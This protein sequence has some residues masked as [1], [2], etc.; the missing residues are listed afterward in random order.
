MTDPLSRQSTNPLRLVGRLARTKFGIAFVLLQKARGQFVRAC[1]LCR[2]VPRTVS[3]YQ[4][5]L[6]L[7]IRRILGVFMREGISG[8]TRRASILVGGINTE[9]HLKLLSTD[10]YGEI[11]SLAP[12]F[13]PK[14]SIIVPNFNHAKYLPERLESIYGQ[15]YGNFEVILLDDCSSD[16]S[17]VILHDYAER[18]SDK[19]ICR[20]NEVNSG[21]VF[22]QWRKGLELATGELVWI[23]ESDDCCS[24]NLLE[25]LVRCFQNPGVMLA[26]AH[27]EFVRGTPAMKAWTSKE[28]LAD[29]GFE[30]WDHPFIKSAHAM[31]KSGWAIKN[32]IPNVSGAVFRHPGKMDILEDSQWL[33]LRM[34]GDW[35]FYLSIIRG[36]LVA[37]N[38]NATNYYR[39]HPQNT[40][41][42]TQR[43]D[44]YYQ[45]H[46]VVALYL[47]KL[48][49]LDRADLERQERVLYQHWCTNRGESKSG[50][51]RKLYDLDKIWHEEEGRRPNIVM[52][53]YALAA[54]GGETFPIMLANLLQYRGY[55]VTLLNCRSETTE[56]GVRRMLL[57]CIP[58]LELDR[59]E[60]AGAVFTDMGIELVHSH[61]AW[62]D[63]TLATLLLPNRDIRQIVTMHGM[64][65]MM[66]PSQLKALL[67]LLRSR[68]DRFV[69]TAGKNL[70]QFSPDFCQEKGF[71]R[72]NNSLPMKKITPIS[73]DELHVGADDFVLC[74]V[75]RAIPDKGW[76]EAI[77]AVAWARARSS[78]KVHL[79]LI[80]E[81]PEF[82]R[83]KSQTPHE[84]VHFLGFRSNIRD[85]FAAS[86]IGF[87][88]SRFKGESSP[89][90]LI[91]CLYSGKPVLASNVGEIRYMLDSSEGLAGEL[92][93]LDEWEIRVEA[94]GQIILTLANDPIAY[95]RLLRCVPLAA[96][97]FDVCTMVDKYEEVYKVTLAAAGSDAVVRTNKKIGG[98]S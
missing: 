70:S 10:L 24:A 86:D 43:E 80:G 28:Y 64:Y 46:Q 5:S 32:I 34:C 30:I 9:S 58:L 79:L 55:A 51:F 35:V 74:L 20:F 11:Q 19:T 77:N 81:G 92:F 66:T 39:Q 94:V 87:L 4:G 21:G 38:P 71:C 42:N 97:K 50:E 22:H 3:F 90:V 61:H 36:G 49:R 68:I 47:A 96:A 73:R 57:G 67:P 26:F 52:G 14:V 48:Y 69:Y 54:G 12:G 18:Y 98:Q 2:A 8:V 29:L 83:L 56:P 59:L 25:E 23:A 41:V 91:D 72:I 53:V 88:P 95:Q 6:W 13:M 16:E 45:E 31:V 65:E 82:D 27:T 84:F 76:E 7:A 17:M 78:R 63:V 62:V 89:L 93:D 37:Y 1:T 60:L 75:A 33:K 15:T 40:S 44:L 85:Y